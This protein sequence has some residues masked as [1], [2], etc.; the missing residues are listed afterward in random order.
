VSGRGNLGETP[1]G[2]R[3][4]YS[5]NLPKGSYTLTLKGILTTAGACTYGI[6]V[7]VN[8]IQGQPITGAIDMGQVF[9]YN[10]NVN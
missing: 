8:G 7:V 10:F 5:I 2:G 6:L 4:T 9:S 1:V 3:R